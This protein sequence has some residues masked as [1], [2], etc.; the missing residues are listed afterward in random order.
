MVEAYGAQKSIYSEWTLA[1]STV[2]QF[3]SFSLHN[4][5]DDVEYT[6]SDAI[7]SKM[8]KQDSSGTLSFQTNIPSEGG[9]NQMVYHIKVRATASNPSVKKWITLKVYVG[10][11]RETSLTAAVAESISALKVK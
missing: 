3:V 2:C 8:Q 4:P 11:W 1:Q 10:C 5:A 6:D 9:V 7:S